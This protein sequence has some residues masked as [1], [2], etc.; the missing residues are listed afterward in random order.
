MIVNKIHGGEQGFNMT[1][2]KIC[3]LQW[4]INGGKKGFSDCQQDM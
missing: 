2:S 3:D 1:V 4:K